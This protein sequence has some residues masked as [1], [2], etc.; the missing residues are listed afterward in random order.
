MRISLFAFGYFIVG[1]Y[2]VVPATIFGLWV[3]LDS[4]VYVAYT[5]V[6]TYL[7]SLMGGREVL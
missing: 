3:I 7:G 2:V 6:K 4:R 5:I 1:P